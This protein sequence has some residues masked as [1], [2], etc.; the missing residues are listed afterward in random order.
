MPHLTA[1]MCLRLAAAGLLLPCASSLANIAPPTATSSPPVAK[2]LSPAT[3]GE[4]LLS[5]TATPI[6][7]VDDGDDGPLLTETDRPGLLDRPFN[8]PQG[9]LQIETGPAAAFTDFDDGD[10]T[11][12]TFPTLIR[13]GLFEFLEVRLESGIYN[14]AMVDTPFGDEDEDG[15]ADIALGAKLRVTEEAGAIPASALIGTVG[16]PTGE[17]PF[18]TDDPTYALDYV[19]GWCLYQCTGLVI[20]GGVLYADLGDGY[21]GTGQL[22]AEL[23]QLLAGRTRLFAEAL[24]IVPFDSDLEDSV[25]VGGGV[26]HRINA[27]MEVDLSVDVNV[28]D[29]APDWLVAGGFSF[30]LR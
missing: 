11:L 17:E 1:P 6:F 30:L 22:G 28:A 29:G 20:E 4:D 15:F 10:V 8:M 26:R 24:W 12:I 9:G 3:V 2:P 13:Y 27:R 23:N 7:A 25:L 21:D 5:L 18:T 16:L 19:A 14:I